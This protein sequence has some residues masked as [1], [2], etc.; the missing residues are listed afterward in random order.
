MNS[1]GCINIETEKEQKKTRVMT[2]SN[3]PVAG[4]T[5]GIRASVSRF[6]SRVDL[7][8]INIDVNSN[9]INIDTSNRQEN[10]KNKTKEKEKH[11]DAGCG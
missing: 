11:M 1:T 5:C 2:N 10:E 3:M 7:D 9:N 6:I 8:L 4:N